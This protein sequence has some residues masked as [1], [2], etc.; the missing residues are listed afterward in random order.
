MFSH[1]STGISGV[2][3]GCIEFYADVAV[4]NQ[5]T[6]YFQTGFFYF[7]SSKCVYSLNWKVEMKKKKAGTFNFYKPLLWAPFFF[8]L[9]VFDPLPSLI[10]I[11]SSRKAF[12]YVTKVIF[13]SPLTE[14][15]I[16]SSH[17]ERSRKSS[18]D[19]ISLLAIS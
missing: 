18:A 4:L 11:I 16:I 14:W 17:Q 7:S 10:S 9:S 1:W 6:M 5:F 19:K 15:C 3:C 8:Q 12:S 13:C 2:K